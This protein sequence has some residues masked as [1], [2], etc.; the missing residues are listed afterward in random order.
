[1][2]LNTLFQN[3]TG[4]NLLKSI[5]S[6]VYSQKEIFIS[7]YESYSNISGFYK[8]TEYSPDGI[9]QSYLTHPSPGLLHTLRLEDGMITN[10]GMSSLNILF[11]PNLS[12]RIRITDP[13]LEFLSS[14][15]D[16]IP[17]SYVRLGHNAGWVGLYLKVMQM[18]PSKYISLLK[19]NSCGSIT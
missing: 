9:I 14:N 18:L 8:G 7:I 15:P 2:D 1:M 16:A 5:E 4:M 12:Y 6:I 17:R 19:L 11:N 13:S 10:R 3:E